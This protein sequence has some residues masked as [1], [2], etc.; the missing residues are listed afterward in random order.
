M[1][2]I[3]ETER[4]L[5]REL[6]P[7]DLTDL[8]KV[9]G[10]EVSMQYY[11]APFDENK[12]KAWINW[13]IDNY[14]Q[15]G[16]GLW[17]VILKQNNTFLGDCGITMQ[18]VEGTWL[19]EIGYHIRKEFCGN[20]YATEAA[21]ACLH[22]AFNTLNYNTVISYMKHDN[23]PSAC[24]AQKIGMKFVRHFHKVV[25]NQPVCEALYHINNEPI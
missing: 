6:N 9:L 1:K 5:L 10:D 24:V 20:G 21:K 14:Q 3:I 15:Y 18:E 23:L 7:T 12:V 16:H 22:Y 17:V 13:N 4:L 2:T 8:L 19:P 11:P 25:M